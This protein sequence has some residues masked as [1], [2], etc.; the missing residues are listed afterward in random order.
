MA[1][2]KVSYSMIQGAYVNVED[3]GASSGAS[4]AT[5]TAAFIAA[6]NAA[7]SNSTGIGQNGNPAGTVFVPRG[8][9]QL[10]PDEIIIPNW[11]NL[12]G[13]G[14]SAT[15]LVAATAGTALI[16]MGT[17]ADPTYR[18]S[19]SGLTIY[20]AGLNITGL[21][22]YASYWMM[23]DVEVSNCNYNGIYLYSSFTGKAYNTYV[24]LCATSPGYAGIYMTGVSTGA[25]ANDINFYGGSL[26]ECYDSVRI[27]NGNGIWF[28]G[29]SVQSSSRHAFVIDASSFVVSGVSIKNCYF[30]GNCKTVAGSIVSGGDLTYLTF[31]NN[32]LAGP[33]AFQVC[34]IRGAGF[35][36]VKIINNLFNA[37]P[38]QNP[39][40]I[41]LENESAPSAVFARN[42]IIGNGSS[43]DAIP[44]FS[45]TLKGFV[46]ANLYLIGG[47]TTNRVD[48]AAQYQYQTNFVSTYEVTFTPSSS[49]TIT[50]DSSNNTALWSKSGRV[51]HVQGRVTVSSVGSPV[52]TSVRISLPEPITDAGENSEVVGGVIIQSSAT[53][54][55]FFGN[56]GNQ[57][58]NMIIDASTVAGTQT[59]SWSFSYVTNDGAL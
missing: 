25:G 24:S 46:D 30:E 31:E 9:Y 49:G 11:V 36:Q 1:L 14:K 55:P 26:Q 52:G 57:Y 43:N 35:N 29:V 33:G 53:A 39:Y 27:Q 7:K 34:T 23:Y 50:L 5:N 41:G 15:M 47:V 40:F 54:L 28:D 45:P 21:Q 20:G 56:G 32:Y 6:L 13:A 12:R 42:L 38:A 48:H 58:V 59:Y 3:F 10:N 51:V 17:A 19:I 44:L 18:T 8:R 37:T 2:T 4:A 16:R 22:I